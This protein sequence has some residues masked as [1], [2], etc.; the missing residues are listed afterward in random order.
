MLARDLA[1]DYPTVTAGTGAVE[2]FQLLAARRLPGLLVLTETGRP[3]AVLPESGLLAQM[4]P[5]YLRDNHAVARTVDEDYADYLCADHFRADLAARQVADLL[6]DRPP[7]PPVV[8]GEATL[9]EIV[10]LLTRT[11]APPRAAMVV[12]IESA[13]PENPATAGRILGIITATELIE[14]GL[15]SRIHGR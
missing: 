13:V 5:E 6:P 11:H 8:D 4:L 15:S 12:V 9:V 10:A 2:A 1:H 7:P 3:Y 14:A